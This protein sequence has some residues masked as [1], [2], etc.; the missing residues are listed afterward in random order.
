[1]LSDRLCKTDDQKRT[2]R[3]LRLKS[4]Y[5]S[6]WKW[7]CQ[8]RDRKGGLTES[9]QYRFDKV[10]KGWNMMNG[11]FSKDDEGFYEGKDLFDQ[12]YVSVWH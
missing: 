7:L 9:R 6:D 12:Y 8:Y 3:F 11:C 5:R 4:M 1:M 2:K 10:E